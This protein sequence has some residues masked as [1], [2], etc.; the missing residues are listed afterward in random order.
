[1][2]SK[3]PMPVEP[4]T[5]PVPSRSSATV[6]SFPSYPFQLMPSSCQS[7]SSKRIDAEL[8]VRA[9]PFAFG[10]SRD[11][12]IDILSLSLGIVYHA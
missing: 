7:S 11:V 2:W 10:E 3:K 4:S 8:G 12:P 1:M 9:Q 5:C 6:S